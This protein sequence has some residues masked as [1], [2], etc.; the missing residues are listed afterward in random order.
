MTGTKITLAHGS[1]GLAMQQLIKDLF[2]KYFNNPH[3]SL[4]EDQAQLS[5]ASFSNSTDK[6][7]FA[8]DSFVIDPITFNGGDI[9]KLAV[10]GTVNDLAVG[11]AIP[12]Y[13]SAGFIIEEGLDLATLELIVKSMAQQAERAGVSI[14]TGDTKVV[15]KGAC[16]KL[17]INTSGIGVIPE[18]R[19]LGVSQVQAGDKV[20]VNGTL[21]DHA[22]A[23]LQ[24]RGELA[25]SGDISSDCAALNELTELMQVAGKVH[26]MRDATRGGVAAVCNEISESS[27]LSIC[28][29][30]T[31]LPIHQ[32]VRAVSEMLGL[33]PLLMA[34][35]GKLVAFV[36]AENADAVLAAMQS[37]PLGKQAA[38][39]GEVSDATTPQVVVEGLY[40]THRQLQMPVGEQLP[41]IC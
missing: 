38:C 2:V 23:I 9:G 36:A 30:E 34:N 13:L 35:E 31:Q 21:G 15:H 19:C 3:L 11:G 24:A 16:D 7:A 18:N 20:L 29:K 27:Q 1:G 6:L 14:V 40:G 22:T 26:A 32:E 33:D 5:L 4:M 41:R 28:L 25:L 8:T 10:C 17:F 37:H 39:I 12:K